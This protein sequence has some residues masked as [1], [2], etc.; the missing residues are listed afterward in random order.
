MAPDL[1]RIR[2]GLRENL[3]QFTWLVV[4]NAFVGAMIGMER[5]ILPA[6]AELYPGYEL[7]AYLGL[8]APARTPGDVV[9]A[10]HGWVMKA[11]DDA[12]VRS[13]LEALGMESRALSREEYRQ[14]MA[15]EIA[16][17]GEYVKAAGIEPQ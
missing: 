10:L 2:L 7:V 9:D 12:G 13:R 8:A 1:A 11:L 4:V 5:S 14:F 6:I 16:R 3:I 15:R 17:W